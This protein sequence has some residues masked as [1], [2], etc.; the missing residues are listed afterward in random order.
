VGLNRLFWRVYLPFLLVA[1]ICV[2]SLMAILDAHGSISPRLVSLLLFGAVAAIVLGFLVARKLGRS[3]G[4]LR[5]TAERVAR[6]GT[7]PAVSSGAVTDFDGIASA[8]NLIERQLKERS[9]I[10]TRQRQEYETIVGSMIE[11]VLAVDPD[12]KILSANRAAGQLLGIDS[13]S[14][15]GHSLPEIV[16][17]SELQKLVAKTQATGAAVAGETAVTGFEERFLQ[18]SCTV[19]RDLA[20]GDQGV[21]VVLNDVTRLR[22]LEEVRRDFVANVSHELKTPIT[23]IKGYVETLLDGALENRE[24]AQR[25]LEIISKQANRL[26]SIIEDLLKLSSVEQEY[27]RGEVI[28][29][30]AKLVIV[31]QSAI[32]ACETQFKAKEIAV[33]LRCDGNLVASLNPPLFEQALVNLIANAIKYSNRGSVVDI[34]AVK[35]GGIVRIDVSD[36]GCGIAVEHLARLFERFYRVDKARSRSDGGTGLGLAIVKHIVQAHR[37]QV[38]VASKVGEGSVFTISLPGD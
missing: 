18:V 8:L 12:Q 38:S 17:N 1:I 34:S 4:R 3:F 14:A 32:S 31:L 15:V 23:S 27:E 21:L 20:G 36:H 29:E 9:G 28:L 30:P 6:V 11:G 25:F 24:D 35:S 2:A 13:D 16:R 10:L 37:G 22:K 33:T 26:Q 19:L 7:P 5:E